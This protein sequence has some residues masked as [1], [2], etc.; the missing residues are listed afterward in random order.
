MKEE[1]H[2]FSVG[3]A[4]CGKDNADLVRGT[5]GT[6]LNEEM[7]AVGDAKAL[8]IW[9]HNNGEEGGGGG[10]GVYRW[11]DVKVTFGDH[12]E[13]VYNLANYHFYR[14][15]PIEL[16]IAGDLK[17]IAAAF[18][19]ENSSG[20]WCPW[21]LRSPK[22]W[23]GGDQ[24][25]YEGP[26]W[27]IWL[28]EEFAEGVSSGRLK[29]S[30]QRKGVVGKPVIDYVG[31]GKI[32]FP[33]LHATLGFGNDWLKS[34]IKEMQAISEAYTTEYM[35][36]EEVMGLTA[37]ALEVAVQRLREYRGQVRDFVRESKKAL[38][39][40]GANALGDVQR[41]MLTVDLEK[42][43]TEIARLQEDVD[44]CKESREAS[45]ETF[46]RE[47]AKDENS[48]AFGQP[49]RKAIE[50][51]LKKHGIDKGAAFGGDIQGNACRKLMEKAGAIVD[52]VKQYMTLPETAATRVVGTEQEILDRCDLYSNLLTAF[53]GC[54]S[55]LRTKRYHVTDE[56]VDQTERYVKKVME[57]SRYLG[58]SV[59]PKQATLF[60]VPCGLSSTKTSR[61]CRF[62]RGCG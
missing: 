23:S 46:E 10:E 60:G 4:Q 55:G 5:F 27:D 24:D 11:D 41:Q 44:S 45:K 30:A 51:I 3:N 48:K 61:V 13:D 22:E 25:N 49:I 16:W 43:E 26:Y 54:I 14:Q 58:L 12:E 2:C 34:F 39:R 47:A 33:I 19:K 7:K 50:Q 38:R 9:L 53:D 15:L 29:S 6:L 52:E 36:A 62:G 40:K 42:I 18:G 56:I 37:A 20:H 59:T 21:C 8:K 17:W 35:V 28:L 31:P 1:Q 32:A 57:L